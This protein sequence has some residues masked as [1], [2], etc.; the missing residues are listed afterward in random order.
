MVE[1]YNR[2]DKLINNAGI[3]F[4]PYS[5][6]V[7]GFENQFGTNHLGHFAL[8]GLLMPLLKKTEASR[9]VV[10]S[11]LA[12]TMGN[13]DLEDLNWEGR[14]YDNQKAYGDSKLACLYFTYELARRLNKEGDHPR[15]TAAH[16]GWAATDLQRNS[17][18]MSGMN[19]FFAQRV[20]MGV[21][22]TLRAAF[23]E[24]AKAVEFYGPSKLMNMRGYPLR[25][26]RTNYPMMK[27]LPENYGNVQRK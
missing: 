8:T 23:D 17:T 20:E 4:G 24:N 7:D 27:P 10:L 9:V 3:M 2:L 26:H 18:L 14:K 15:I 25:T 6:K 12:H 22:P 13:L 11:S 16:P 21:L 19:K 5:K 1:N